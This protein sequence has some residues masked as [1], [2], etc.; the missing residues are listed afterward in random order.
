MSECGWGEKA[1]E[2]G[3]TCQPPKP[4]LQSSS[5][6][7]QQLRRAPTG[8]SRQPARSRAAAL[9]R[10]APPRL[11]WRA[12]PRALPYCHTRHRRGCL[13]Q[14]HGLQHDPPCLGGTP[15]Q[16]CHGGTPCQHA[17]SVS[18]TTRTYAP[19][20]AHRAGPELQNGSAVRVCCASNHAALDI[21]LTYAG[22]T[23]A[24]WREEG[25]QQALSEWKAFGTCPSQ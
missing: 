22:S 14:R 2:E 25:G 21:E 20:P 3:Q 19:T 12:P 1:G 16:P 6:R 23:S 5:Q 24:V 18:E 9:T 13:R 11:W 15:C 7:Q 4:P 10:P 17:K 8:R